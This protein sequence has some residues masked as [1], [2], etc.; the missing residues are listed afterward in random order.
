MRIAVYVDCEVANKLKRLREETGKTYME[1]AREALARGVFSWDSRGPCRI[2][3]S[4]GDEDYML[5]WRLMPR[6]KATC[7]REVARGL[8]AGYARSVD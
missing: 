2:T 4:L 3:L 8:L 5:L 6:F 7:I 1:M